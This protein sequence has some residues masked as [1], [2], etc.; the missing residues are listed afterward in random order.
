MLRKRFVGV[1][2][3]EKVGKI[4]PCTPTDLATF[5][6]LAKA[7]DGT[8]AAVAQQSRKW[9]V[10]GNQ[11]LVGAGTLPA[12]LFCIAKGHVNIL[13]QR[14]EAPA[15]QVDLIGPHTIIGLGEALLAQP[16][17][18][19]YVTLSDTEVIATPVSVVAPLLETD[20]RLL[21][22]LLGSLSLR[23]HG[24]VSRINALKSL[25]AE[26]RLVHHLL[27]L[28][29]VQSGDGAFT[30]PYDK[31]SLA[32]HLA[33]QPESLSRLLKKLRNDGVTI[34]GNRVQIADLHHLRTL[35]SA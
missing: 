3:M 10:P 22:S 7:G 16:L 32:A 21:F 34:K 35:I 12:T 5:P 9:I 25:T 20:S 13:E 27:D 4:E 6:A 2:Q 11:F 8:R 31:K 26:Q 23:I 1:K 19:D 30:M 17:A 18:Y 14:Q 15:L 24:L 33:V 28:A 29:A